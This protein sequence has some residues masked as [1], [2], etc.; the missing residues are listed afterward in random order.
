MGSVREDRV[1]GCTNLEPTLACFTEQLG[2]RLE[3]IA[4]ADDP[5]TAVISGHG[6]RLRLE[7][8]PSPPA[9]LP[10]RRVVTR[11]SDGDWRR[12]RAGMRYRDLLPDRHRGRVIASHIH[13]PEGGPVADYVHFHDVELQLIYCYKGW[14]RV[15][16]EDQGPA[17]ALRSGDCVLQPP[18]IR[19][20]VLECSPDLEVIEVSCPAE[21]ETFREH[22]LALPTPRHSPDRD[23]AGQRFVR[24]EA[25]RAA[26]RPWLLPGWSCRDTGIG[27][28]TRGLAS[29]VVARPGGEGTDVTIDG[30]LWLWVILSG[31]MTLI[32][33][34]S[35]AER[36]GG[37]D[38]A[39]LTAG[40]VCRLSDCSP[41][42]ELLA[43]HLPG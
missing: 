10:P 6:M 37:G 20:R 41:D 26:W 13:I 43:I 29:A 21:H 39:S 8:P 11:A 27:E 24:H 38:A 12:G 18:H 40:Q 17:F 35:A 9:P 30:E 2:F 14:V 42:L 34:G 32:P 28:A 3:S 33:A 23:F 4:P 15:V 19:H 22:E 1:L 25:D 7:R 5:R 31:E 16:Y 36:I